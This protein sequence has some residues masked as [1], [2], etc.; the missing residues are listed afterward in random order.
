[1]LVSHAHIDPRRLTMFWALNLMNEI[2]YIIGAIL[3]ASL[4]VEVVDI[5][6]SFVLVPPHGFHGRETLVATL[7]C[8]WDFVCCGGHDQKLTD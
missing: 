6:F 3:I 5:I 7:E 1:M 2:L 8:A 4:A